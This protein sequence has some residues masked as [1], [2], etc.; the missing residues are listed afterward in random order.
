MRCVWR[1]SGVVIG[2]QGE[3]YDC[4]FVRCGRFLDVLSTELSIIRGC[5]FGCLHW[6]VVSLYMI[7]RE[8]T[9][10]VIQIDEKLC[11]S[12]RINNSWPSLLYGLLW[13]AEPVVVQWASVA[14]LSGICG[15]N[16]CSLFQYP[17]VATSCCAITRLRTLDHGHSFVCVEVL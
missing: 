12:R 9:S 13:L 1:L 7:H 15:T 3:R 8:Y 2:Q 16:S 5:D 14:W 17:S 11:R 6:V 4:M 10:Q